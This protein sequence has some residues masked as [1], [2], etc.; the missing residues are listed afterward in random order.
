MRRFPAYERYRPNRSFITFFF[1]VD[2]HP[3]KRDARAIRRNLWIADPDEIPQVFFGDGAF[4]GESSA[5]AKRKKNDEA[6]MTNDEGITKHE[7][8]NAGSTSF[9]HLII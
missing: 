3:H 9:P 1:L 5:D 4:F 8:R 2:R 6:R 7:V